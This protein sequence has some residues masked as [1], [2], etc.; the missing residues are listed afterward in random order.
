MKFQDV[1]AGALAII[2]LLAIIGLIYLE[3]EIPS[4]LWTSL[5]ISM[6]WVFSRAVNGKVNGMQR[7]AKDGD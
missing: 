4:E 2:L 6:G 7:R 1:I 3:R 5:G